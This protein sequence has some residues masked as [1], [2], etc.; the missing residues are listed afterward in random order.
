MY[1]PG[2]RHA[3]L[4]N[5]PKTTT[6][7]LC[8]GSGSDPDLLIRC[9]HGQLWGLRIFHF[10]ES[11]LNFDRT[12]LLERLCPIFLCLFFAAELNDIKYSAYRT[13]MKLRCI[14]KATSCELFVFF[15]FF[16]EF[17]M[18]FLFPYIFHKPS[19][20]V[21]FN[22]PHSLMFKIDLELATIFLHRVYETKRDFLDFD[23]RITFQSL[24]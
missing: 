18:L 12:M 23:P 22:V 14:Q 1:T 3:L 7:R 19:K 4:L 21:S 2:W 8:W 20:G 11:K 6:Q 24:F 10:L 9:P 15:V 5:L 13:A 17:L 16:V